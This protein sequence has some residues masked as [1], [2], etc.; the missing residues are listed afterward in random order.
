MMVNFETPVGCFNYR[1]G[2]IIIDD[3]HLLLCRD[4]RSTV[5]FLPG[6]RVEMMEASAE[7][8]CREMREELATDCQ[9]G[10]LV[11]L[12]ENFFTLND[13]P[14]HEIGLYYLVALPAESPRHDKRQPLSFREAVG[15]NMEM[16]WFRLSDLASIDLRPA[17][18]RDNL[19]NLPDSTQAVVI[20]DSTKTSPH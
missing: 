19:T 2:A 20:R 16:Q 14:F 9:V 5:W 8:L 3:E 7:S 18:L 12:T 6:G 15:A 17:F 13:R 11:W 4:A 10:R 1:V